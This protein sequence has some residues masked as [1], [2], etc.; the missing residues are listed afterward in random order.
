MTIRLRSLPVLLAL[1]TVA[2]ASPAGAAPDAP[3]T[4]VATLRPITPGLG[5]GMAL[6]ISRD[7]STVVVSNYGAAHVGV[8]GVWVLERAAGGWTDAAHATQLPSYASPLHAPA[9]AV[10]ADGATVVV[11]NRS[12]AVYVFARP[13]GGWSGATVNAATAR[14]V[15]SDSAITARGFGA[16]VAISGDTI[17]VGVPGGTLDGD[18]TG[19]VDVFVRG[20]GGWVDAAETAR[21]T[22]NPPLP[23]LSLGRAVAI[24]DDTIVADT[25]RGQ[26]P[27]WF[28]PLLVFVRPPGGWLAATQT[29]TLTMGGF[30]QDSVVRGDVTIVGDAIAASTCFKDPITSLDV[31]DVR[32]FARPAGGWVDSSTP[33]ARLPQ[34]ADT[35]RTLL[36]G[37]LAFDGSTIALGS[38]SSTGYGVV[39]TYARPAAGWGGTPAIQT[40]ARP[41]GAAATFGQFGLGVGGPTLVVGAPQDAGDQVFLYGRPVNRATVAVSPTPVVL[42]AAATTLTATCAVTIGT[43][44]RCSVTARAGSTVVAS[45]TTILK[46]PAARVVVRL[47]VNAAG[48][49]AVARKGGRVDLVVTALV[50]PTSGPVLAATTASTLIAKTVTIT[51]SADVLFSSGSAVLTTAA[52]ATIASLGRHLKGSRAARCD[53]HTDSDGSAAANLDLGKRRAAAVCSILARYVRKT[54]TRTFGES[55]PIASNATAKGKARNR[56]VEITVTN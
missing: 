12:D 10:S 9:V 28:T 25:L 2:L 45:G 54:T 48:R 22:S 27:P 44:R 21:L 51:L 39:V 1:S 33:T 40:I 14:L 3:R 7:G 16:D 23:G 53:G 15:P 26:Q 8:P 35:P 41:A 32:V 20:A 34:P 52:K 38:G 24:D 42:K 56:R 50:T 11:G 30:C 13:P 19:E 17:V 47:T 18:G 46:A 4:L 43:A 29:A 31:G 37:P 49:K 36:G 5:L 6:A 55:R